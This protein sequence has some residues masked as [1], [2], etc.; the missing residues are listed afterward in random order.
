[1]DPNE[2]RKVVKIS[3]CLRNELAE[4]RVEFLKKNQDVFAW[5]HADMIGIHPDMMCH[6]LNI[7]SHAKP[8]HQKQKALDADRYKALQEEVHCLLR[9]GF[10]RESYCPD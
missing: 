5:T 2:P 7:D 1:M 6:R 3:K 4:Q 9:I 10:I 8:V